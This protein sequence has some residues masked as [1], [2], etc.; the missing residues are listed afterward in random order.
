MRALIKVIAV[1]APILSGLL[2]YV[3]ELTFKPRI[4]NVKQDLIMQIAFR[5]FDAIHCFAHVFFVCYVM[6][7]ISNLT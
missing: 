2:K 4:A 6:R 7:S 5:R 1:I 3:F